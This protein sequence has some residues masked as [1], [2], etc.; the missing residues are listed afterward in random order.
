[1]RWRRCS[2]CWFKWLQQFSSASFSF[3]HS[4]FSFF[5][6]ILNSNLTLGVIEE[7]GD[8]KQK[9]KKSF[10][11]AW[12]VQVSFSFFAFYFFLSFF[13]I[14][15]CTCNYSSSWRPYFI[16]CAFSAIFL[17]LFL[18]FFSSSFALCAW[19]GWAI[20]TSSRIASL[21]DNK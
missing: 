21:N 6:L 4:I 11:I 2:K 12:T 16:V 18:F 3:P 1:M 19:F 20:W 5:F 7:T 8:I 13:L 14:A 17:F 9:N 10:H 15:F